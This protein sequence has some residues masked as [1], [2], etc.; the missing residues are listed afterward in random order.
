[1]FTKNHCLV[2]NFNNTSFHSFLSFFRLAICWCLL[3]IHLP[4]FQNILDW[5]QVEVVTWPVKGLDITLLHDVIISKKSHIGWKWKTDFFYFD[6]V[7]KLLSE[8]FS[9]FWLLIFSTTQYVHYP[10]QYHEHD[11]CSWSNCDRDLVSCSIFGFLNLR[12]LLGRLLIL[13]Y[14]QNSIWQLKNTPASLKSP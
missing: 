6:I 14:H 1:M 5:M 7:S 9:E 11:I 3:V 12:N 10:S 13:H 8:F 4:I 2:A